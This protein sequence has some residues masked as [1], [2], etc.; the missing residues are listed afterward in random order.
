[1]LET[2]SPYLTPEPLRGSPNEPGFLPHT[3]AKLAEIWGMDSAEVA[4][5]TSETAARVFGSPRG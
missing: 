3:G 4:R 1:M 5:M 2:D